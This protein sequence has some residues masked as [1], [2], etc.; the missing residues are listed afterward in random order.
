MS[1]GPQ[2]STEPVGYG[3]HFRNTTATQQGRV[4]IN[5]RYDI[6][7]WEN[8]KKF[9]EKQDR[10]GYELF[11]SVTNTN[12]EQ[13]IL[14]GMLVFREKEYLHRDPMKKKKYA[15]HGSMA[16]FGDPK[17]FSTLNGAGFFKSDAYAKRLKNDPKLKS[18]YLRYIRDHYEFVGIAQGGFNMTPFGLQGENKRTDIAVQ[19]GGIESVF[20]TGSKPILQGMWIRYGVPDPT[21]LKLYA[22]R[23]KGNAMEGITDQ[24][25][26]FTMEPY[27]VEE[28]F[29]FDNLHKY[30]KKLFT[31]CVGFDFGNR[32]SFET[33]VANDYDEFKN[34]YSLEGFH[35][36]SF[37]FFFA[38]MTFADVG[39]NI[40]DMNNRSVWDNE[41][42]RQCDIKKLLSQSQD[43]MIKGMENSPE[44]ELERSR[45]KRALNL[46]LIAMEV[47]FF[48]EQTNLFK[49]SGSKDFEIFDFKNY[50]SSSWA[51]MLDVMLNYNKSLQNTIIGRALT[52]G[53]P[54]ETIDII[55]GLSRSA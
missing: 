23:C 18:D 55:V 9:V 10:N 33:Y 38:L 29:N 13:T 32:N 7:R 54:G 17:I 37:S 21:E 25:V 1:L 12:Y 39:N 49:A 8:L 26:L 5:C 53:N 40:F 46:A 52:S 31:T 41:G 27:E 35:K 16:D 19:I 36:A 28:E 15:F 44:N 4:V 42:L 3:G 24:T 6:E 11:Y 34:C 48:A 22:P 20:I 30:H 43:L 14:Q 2:F 47:T 50:L 45:I 51:A